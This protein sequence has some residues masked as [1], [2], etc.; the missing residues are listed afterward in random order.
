M[1]GFVLSDWTIPNMTHLRLTDPYRSQ[2]ATA[3]AASSVTQKGRQSR[4][5]QPIQC[6]LS[7][8]SGHKTTQ[9]EMTAL[10]PLADMIAA[11][12]GYAP[13]NGRDGHLRGF[14]AKAPAL[15]RA[16]WPPSTPQPLPPITTRVEPGAVVSIGYINQ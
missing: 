10:L 1:D 14:G 16:L 4:I 11:H 3:S 2:L 12:V 6:P 15:T 5:L 8:I 7:V 9:L 13:L